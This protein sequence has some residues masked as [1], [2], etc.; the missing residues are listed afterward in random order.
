MWLLVNLG[1]LAVAFMIIFLAYP[2]S[3]FGT[4]KPERVIRTE[5]LSFMLRGPVT[6]IA[7]LVV[8]LFVPR[9]DV[10]GLPGSALM[11]F[12]AVATVLFF[13]WMIAI[14]EPVLERALVYT[15]DQDQA[16]R[17][18]QFSERLL[19]RTD[20]RQ[21]LE[22]ILAAICDY[23][24]VPSA[25]VA[26]INGEVRIEQ[27]V[28]VLLPAGKLELPE[29]PPALP[30]SAQVPLTQWQSYWLVPLYTMHTQNT[31]SQNG[32]GVQRA[33]GVIGIWARSNQPD[34]QAEEHAVFA[35]LS[36]RA[37][38]VLDDLRIQAELLERVEDVIEDELPVRIEY[39]PP[40]VKTAGSFLEQEEFIEIVHEALKH[41]WGGSRLVDERLL[42]LRIVTD[43]MQKDSANAA[44]AVRTVLSRAIERLKPKTPRS[45][46]AS[47][48]TLYNILDLRFVQGKRVK[49][50]APQM[51]MGDANFYRK[52]RVAI[53]ALA[54]EIREMERQ[55]TG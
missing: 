37:A 2:L 46:I 39:Q 36:M 55:Q 19:T 14:F 49:D 16:R 50:V 13:Q 10:F 31:P 20:A 32:T 5:L 38:E 29:L 15:D 4:N 1:N 51:A 11:P 44:Q 12:I 7:V 18:M 23:L 45:M 22:G 21:L 24:R 27:S 35:S 8:I 6:A 43:A 17:L 34:L 26:S 41:Y 47:E 30:D 9:L 28:G 40:T 3:F 48:W 54:Q 42:Q 52:Q 33:I 53:E 25:F